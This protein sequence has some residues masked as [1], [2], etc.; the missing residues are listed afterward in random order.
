MRCISPI[1]LASSRSEI[2]SESALPS[3]LRASFVEIMISFE[4]RKLSLCF[5]AF[6]YTLGI[7]GLFRDLLRFLGLTCCL[8]AC[9]DPKAVYASLPT[10]ARNSDVKKPL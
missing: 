5:C 4:H 6:L 2:L 9:C 10:I 3:N 1:R 8:F 7:C